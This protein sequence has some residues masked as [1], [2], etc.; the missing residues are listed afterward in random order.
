M[1][2]L[3]QRMLA[4]K[5]RKIVE[6]YKPT[7]VAITG[8]VGKTST[9]NAIAEVLGAK[10][11][12]RTNAE[13]YNNEFGVPLTIIGEKSP[14]R[15]VL[16]WLRVFWK[17][18]KLILGSDASYPNMLVLEYGID[19]PGDMNAL[20]DIATPDVAVLTA[21]SPVHVENFPDVDALA[22]EKGT[23]LRRVKS[24]GRAIVN[25]DDERVLGM[26]NAAAAHVV[27]YGFAPQA[28]VRA[29]NYRMETREDFSFE[30][31]EVF[32]EIHFDAITPQER[33]PATLVNLVGRA[34]A[35]AAIAAVAVGRAF[36]VPL[37][38]MIERLTRVTGQAGRMRPIPGIKGSLIL[39]D[40]YNAAPAAMKAA[41]D[42]LAQFHPA[43]NAKR[44]AVLGKMA[45][46]GRY[47][48]E[49]HKKI[50]AQ[51]A[52]SG[53]SL[54]VTITE[55]AQDIR[56]GAIAAGFPE[57]QTQHF[58]SSDEAGR[59]L[60]FHVKKGDIV[61]VKGAQSARTEK[62]V[63]DLMAEPLHAPTLLVR[64]YGAWLT[65]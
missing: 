56:R 17:A 11:V 27:T 15:S 4:W 2:R 6:K 21:I 42:V 26:R 23:I 53:V 22:E 3:V 43:E 65:E 35:S 13:N 8:S 16:G 32:S 44:I 47:S 54:L 51:V 40:S 38:T 14:E 63:K 7:V 52:A 49:E 64:Q 1:K 62:V 39:D 12:I 28:E 36:D 37:A 9:R 33:A 41:V 58:S 31:G 29:E 45:E 60:D 19:R 46:L 48:E 34:Q 20:C 61:L 50:G 59:W 55:P 30:P 18:D 57:S 24:S 10:F 25:A 5:A